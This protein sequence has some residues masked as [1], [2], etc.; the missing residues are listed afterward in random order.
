MADA[1]I[2]DID[3][4]QWNIKDQEARNK[5]AVIENNGTFIN[6]DMVFNCNVANQYNYGGYVTIPKGTWLAM[7]HFD[8]SNVTSLKH[9]LGIDPGSELIPSR[10]YIQIDGAN[11][12]FGQVNCIIQSD[13]T[14]RVRPCVFNYGVASSDL[15]A[16]CAYS[17]VKLHD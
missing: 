2:I 8:F 6:N 16:V 14:K 15:K 9:L 12:G 3:N 1:K 5:I 10:S 11:G 13:G 7:F 4:V 17:L